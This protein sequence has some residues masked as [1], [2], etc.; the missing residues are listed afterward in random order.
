MSPHYSPQ[1][2]VR[3]EGG[4]I[5]LELFVLDAPMT[6]RNFVKLAREG[7]YDGLEVHDVVPNGYIQTGD[8]RGDGNGGPGYSIRSEINERPIVRGTLAMSNHGKDTA[9][10]RFFI[11]HLPRPDLDG[12]NTVFGQVTSGM[13]IV[14]RLEPGDTILEVS[15]WDGFTSPYRGN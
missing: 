11:T 6:V 14:D 1:A 8:P 5:E 15:I 4:V 12:K 9:G 13:E 10:S 7:F 3:T 2:F